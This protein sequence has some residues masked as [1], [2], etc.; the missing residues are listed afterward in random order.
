M[1]F[2]RLSC[3]LVGAFVSLSFADCRF[4]VLAHFDFISPVLFG[5][6]ITV[7]HICATRCQRIGRAWPMKLA[8]SFLFIFI[9]FANWMLLFKPISR[10]NDYWAKTPHS[11]RHNIWVK[12]LPSIRSFVISRWQVMKYFATFAAKNFQFFFISLTHFSPL[13]EFGGF[14]GRSVLIIIMVSFFVSPYGFLQLLFLMPGEP[15]AMRST[16]WDM[17][18]G[19]ERW[20]VM[21]FWVWVE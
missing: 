17:R 9:F 19:V 16:S 1:S 10:V 20:I 3:S 7:P 8:A 15:V 14:L 13:A 2:P 6:F 21:R 11:F 5:A 4:F 18:L 12:F